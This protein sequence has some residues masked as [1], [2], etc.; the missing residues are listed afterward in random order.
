MRGT[1]REP[2][3]ADAAR[4][5]NDGDE[6]VAWKGRPGMLKIVVREKQAGN[7]MKFY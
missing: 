6:V 7:E 1:A 2:F 5:S 4:A 3:P